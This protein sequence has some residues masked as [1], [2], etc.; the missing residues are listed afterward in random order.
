MDKEEP[1]IM[2]IPYTRDAVSGQDFYNREN[3]LKELKN[4]EN[5]R[6]NLIIGARRI[7]KTSLLKELERQITDYTGDIALYINLQ[8]I[9]S[10][11]YLPRL[12]ISQCQRQAAFQSLGFYVT[13]F[14]GEKDF[15]KVLNALDNVLRLNDKFLFLLVDEAGKMAN[16]ELSFCDSLLGSF[17]TYSNIRW[18][19]TDSQPIYRVDEER[20]GFLREFA[21]YIYLPRLDR[22]SSI[23]LIRQS[24][25]NEP[26]EVE[27]AL[28]KKIYQKTGGHPYLLQ[29]L[30][31]H[32]YEDGCLNYSTE[33]Y[34]R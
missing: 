25:L 16:Y 12:F 13:E 7:G 22:N 11:D 17:D 31:L 29:M 23:D 27:C 28:A 26:V 18:I 19:L 2:N 1:K 9:P 34:P 6:C 14:E 8:L 3:L 32:L 30:C 5:Q 20:G 4:P 15:F 33:I 21:P 24:N 10:Q